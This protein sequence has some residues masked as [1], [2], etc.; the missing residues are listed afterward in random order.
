MI[1]SQKYFT[2]DGYLFQIDKEPVGN[3][4]YMLLDYGAKKCDKFS[5]TVHKDLRKDYEVYEILDALD[6]YLIESVEEE[7]FPFTGYGKGKVSI[8][9]LN[10]DSLEILKRYSNRLYAWQHPSLPED[11][12]FFDSDWN[13]WLWNIAHE[14][15]ACIDIKDVSEAVV[16]IDSIGLDGKFYLDKLEF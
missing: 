15:L 16:L 14:Q 4:Y 2:G 3:I 5:L 8:Y 11:L 12:S 6:E 10:K 9:H 7:D 1:N 13:N